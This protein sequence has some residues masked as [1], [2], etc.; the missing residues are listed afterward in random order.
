M[1]RFVVP[2]ALTGSALVLLVVALIVRHEANVGQDA[3]QSSLAAQGIV[4][5]PISQL[6]PAEKQVPCLIQNAG[7]VILTGAQAECYA[8]GQIAND[9][10]AITGGKTYYQMSLPGRLDNLKAEFLA[11]KNPRNPEIGE[12]IA[13][14][15]KLDGPVAPVFQGEALRG[16]LLTSYG[17]SQVASLSGEAADV[18]FVLVALLLLAALAFVAQ[19]MREVSV[20][21][22]AHAVPLAESA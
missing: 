1:K 21:S 2:I 14:A 12:L 7:K 11:L 19:R 22:V 15:Q 9:L 13:A 16:M 17:F 5:S 3:V 4:F 8:N 20:P 18:L 6:S 10:D